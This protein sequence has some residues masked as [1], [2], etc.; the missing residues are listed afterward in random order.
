M[1]KLNNCESKKEV[2]EVSRIFYV[3]L[4][5]REHKQRLVGALLSLHRQSLNLIPLY[6]RFVGNLQFEVPRLAD[7]LLEKLKDELNRRKKDLKYL[8]E[9]IRNVR[10]MAELTK[11]GLVGPGEVVELLK[12]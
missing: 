2:D 8:E 12:E 11:F 10:Y 6:C 3:M 9:K 4:N 5:T 7:K 1:R